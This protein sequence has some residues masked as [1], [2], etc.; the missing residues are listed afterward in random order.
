MTD[1]HLRRT[2]LPDFDASTIHHGMTT[3]VAEIRCGR[4]ASIADKGHQ[5][6]AR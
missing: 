4:G 2:E 1:R 5:A 3:S 6:E